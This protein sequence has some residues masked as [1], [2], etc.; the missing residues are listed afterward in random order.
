MFRFCI[1]FVDHY[2]KFVLV[3]L[4]KAKKEVL[5]SLKKFVLW[6]R[7]R[8]RLDISKEF[9]SEQFKMYCLDTG[10]LQEKTIP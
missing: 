4:H 1:V 2:T 8:I 7:P 9:I 3:D 10:I 5:A 6:G